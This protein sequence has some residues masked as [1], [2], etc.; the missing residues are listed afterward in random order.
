MSKILCIFV[1]SIVVGSVYGLDTEIR[2]NKQQ[3]NLI[4]LN[5][6]SKRFIHNHI[7]INFT[8]E[9]INLIIFNGY[10][11]SSHCAYSRY[12][13]VEGPIFFF[14]ICYSFWNGSITNENTGI[15]EIGK[16]SY[17]FSLIKNNKNDTLISNVV[18]EKSNSPFDLFLIQT[19]KWNENKTLFPR[20][21]ITENNSGVITIYYKCAISKCNRLKFICNKLDYEME[22]C[23]ISQNIVDDYIEYII[24]FGVVLF[25]MTLFICLANIMI[26]YEIRFYL[27]RIIFLP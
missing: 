19:E 10:E 23:D 4:N 16:I 2:Y 14:R 21:Q 1:V 22:R 20:I 18:W 15:I 6:S 3:D 17:A 7:N 26:I 8:I 24:V 5:I 13:I 11:A 25:F 12:Y 9:D 27:Y